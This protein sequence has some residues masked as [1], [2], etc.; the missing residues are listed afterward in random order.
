MIFEMTKKQY[1]LFLHVM[2]VMQTF[3][4]NDFSSICKEV[5]DAYGVHD[6]DI[7]KAYTMFT[8]FKVTTPVP[9]MQNAAKEIYHT[10][11]SAT[12]IE[13]ENKENPYT[14][15]IDMNES[16]WVKAAAI[17]DAYSRILMGQ[18]SIIY[19]VLDIADTDN[20][21]QLQAYHDARW[22]GVG[23]AEARD[24]LLPQLRKLRVGWN[25]N[26]G[27]SNA[28]LAYNSKLAYEMLKAI[29]YACRQGDGTV[30][31]V[32]DE[33]LMYAPGKSNIHAL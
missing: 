2:Q 3:Y 7:E 15:R 32:T 9:S 22:G 12:N 16:A 8:D 23:I 28:G 4:G 6:A 13:A 10:A 1:Q 31:K 14:K 18:F 27:I 33:P 24:L 25:G 30:L 19:E 17:L 5:G 11:L 20:K 21:P 29:L 26:F